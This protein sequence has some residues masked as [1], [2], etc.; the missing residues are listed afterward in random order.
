MNFSVKKKNELIR[1][2][3]IY[4]TWLLHR[5]MLDDVR[6]F[7]SVKKRLVESVSGLDTRNKMPEN[8]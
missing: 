2:D 5:C 7:V 6:K 1:L 4:C 3:S 8:S